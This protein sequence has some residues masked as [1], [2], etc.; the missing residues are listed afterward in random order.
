MWSETMMRGCERYRTRLV[1]LAAVALVGCGS[2][3][4]NSGTAGGFGASDTTGASDASYGDIGGGSD[5]GSGGWG[6]GSQPWADTAAGDGGGWGGGNDVGASDASADAGS[7]KED[8][9]SW[10]QQEQAPPL[11]QVSLGGGQTLD[12][13]D[14]RVVVKV[15]G[16]RARVL[17]DHIFHN[18]HA[19]MLEGTFRYTLPA[20]SSVSYF[21]MFPGISGKAP[22]LFGEGEGL[23]EGKALGLGE[24]TPAEQVGKIDPAQWGVVKTAQ[25]KRTVQATQAYEAEVNKTIDP[26]LVEEIAPNTYSAKVYPLVGG[27]YQRILIAYEQTLPTLQAEVPGGAGQ[28]GRVHELTFALPQGKLGHADFTL[29]GKKAWIAAGAQIGAVTGVQQSETAAGYLARWESKGP[30]SFA[31][32]AEGKLVF[33]FA[34]AQGDAAAD[35]LAG[36][37]PVLGKNVGLVRV[38][39]TLPEAALLPG[40][41][42]KHAVF[43]LDTSRSSHPLRFGVALKLMQEILTASS[44]IEG[45]GVIAFDS[46][47]SWIGPGSTPG[48]TVPPTS[49]IANDAAGR[50]AAVAAFDGL[51]LEGGSDVG[52]ALRALAAPPSA[53]LPAGDGPDAAAPLDVFLLSDGAL[54]W[55][56]REPGAIVARFAAESPWQTRFFAYRLGIGAEN[57]ALFTALTAGSGAVFECL[58]AASLPECAKAHQAAG[59]RLVSASVVPAGADGSGAEIADLLVAGGQQTLYPGVSLTLAGPLVGSGAAKVVLQGA[60]ADGKAATVEVPVTLVPSGEL[61]PRAWGELAVAQLVGSG[62]TALEGLALALAQHYRVASPLGAFLLL[63]NQATWEQ[64]DFGE[65]STKL[66][67]QTIA[68]AIAAAAKLGQAAFS[69][70]ARL[71]QTLAEHAAGFGLP[72]VAAEGWVSG[73][74]AVGAGQLELSPPQLPWAGTPE[75]GV[76]PAY[77]AALKS[78]DFELVAP[79]AAQAEARLEQADVAGAVRALSTVLERAPGDDEL[80]RLIGYRIAGW[81]EASIAAE[82]LFAVL[83][84][85]PF[86]PQSWRDF[87]GAVAQNRPGLAVLAY[88]IA[89]RGAWPSQYKGMAIVAKEEY[90]AFAFDLLGAAPN[91]PLAGLLKQR[92]AEHKLI[93]PPGEMRITATWNTNQT[94]IDLHVTTPLGEVCNYTHKKLSDGSGE[95]YADLTGGYGPERFVAYK[96]MKGTWKVEVHFYNA[97][98]QQ[99]APETWVQVRIWRKNGKVPMVTQ[100]QVVLK[101]EGDK[102]LVATIEVP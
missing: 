16:L 11:A 20:E 39:P 56:D 82:L 78:E 80:A 75:K 51:L 71:Q 86:E 49:W 46:G 65:E 89:L 44:G 40:Q 3:S 38:R 97:P 47:A 50:A 77:D 85:R 64:Y 62:K 54:T 9:Q 23:V 57:A 58:S 93:E 92:I 31:T 91:H 13:V 69:T 74:L 45:F 73:L 52:A 83:L 32:P 18:P 19:G 76:S 94:D 5:A 55:G 79:F 42:A 10:Q 36:T 59:M 25:I 22:A 37:D 28:V 72:G 29:L 100:S 88:E 7:G 53:L 8:P 81:G 101:K 95:L 14:M 2:D 102:L 96:P 6:G 17:V 12:L 35:V 60:L 67:G 63:E 87:A 26:A 34:P 24:L 27:G 15:E 98:A 99:L 4:G 1:L 66:A 33:R 41:G 84:R 61:A 30:I 43:L 21:A 48:A 70:W 90:A 68:K